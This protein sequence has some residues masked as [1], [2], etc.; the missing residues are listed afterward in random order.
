[1]P[2]APVLTEIHDPNTTSGAS[3]SNM[4]PEREHELALAVDE[5]QALLWV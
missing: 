3:V 5:R 1:M 4:T 2:R